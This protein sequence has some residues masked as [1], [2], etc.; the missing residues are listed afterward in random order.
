LIDIEEME[1]IEPI[2]AQTDLLSILKEWH[3]TTELQN[4]SLNNYLYDRYG[5]LRQN[6]ELIN[7]SKEII[8]SFITL[9]KED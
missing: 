6:D 8:E 3:S 9:L 7:Q 5:S 1:M 2:L 4:W